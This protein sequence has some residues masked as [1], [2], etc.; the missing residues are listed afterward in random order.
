MSHRRPHFA[1]AHKVF[2]GTE[3]LGL[4]QSRAGV[5]SESLV[6]LRE[7]LSLVV[8]EDSNADPYAMDQVGA[9]L[10]AF[11]SRH[12]LT[13]CC[14]HTSA[15]WVDALRFSPVYN[16]FHDGRAKS[17]R[18]CTTQHRRLGRSSGGEAQNK[19]A[20]PTSHCCPVPCS[21]PVQ[22]TCAE[23]V[24][25]TRSIVTKKTQFFVVLNH[26][27]PEPD[28]TQAMLSSPDHTPPRPPLCSACRMKMRRRPVRATTGM[29]S[30][31]GRYT[32]RRRLSRFSGSCWPTAWRTWSTTRWWC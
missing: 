17:A 28:P 15:H 11:V 9:C 16:S 8:N 22:I 29:F 24:V 21:E 19:V 13:A 14:R 7:A 3:A 1:Q 20:I 31:A 27:C 10:L 32:L 23:C 25:L 4:M 5:T 30:A 12:T 2:K 6:H 26:R 18:H